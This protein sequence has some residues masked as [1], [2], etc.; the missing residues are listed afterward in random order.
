[1]YFEKR[2]GAYS[3]TVTLDSK[4]SKKLF[5]LLFCLI[6]FIFMLVG[7]IVIATTPNHEDY[8]KTGE[9]EFFF[10][11]NLRKT[12]T[13]RT[14]TNGVSRNKTTTVYVPMYLG[15]VGEDA[16]TYEYHTD[17]PSDDKAQEFTNI[18]QNLKVSTYLD[19]RNQLFLLASDTSLEEYF[20]AQ[21]L[22]GTIFASCGGIS[23]VLGLLIGLLPE[24]KKKDTFDYDL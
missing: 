20:K 5:L 7:G 16:Y 3:K 19:D 24:K 18:N 13:S 4:K 8:E 23:F 17:F 14:R 9:Y 1:M 6:G 21:T 12:S 2:F 15:F 10:H 11:E 22:F